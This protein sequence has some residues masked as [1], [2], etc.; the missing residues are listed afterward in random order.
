MAA[1]RRQLPRAAQQ[2]LLQREW[3]QS[4]RAAQQRFFS[5][6][7]GLCPACEECW[8]PGADLLSAQL[9]ISSTR[10]RAGSCNPKP[11]SLKLLKPQNHPKTPLKT[12]KTLNRSTPKP[13]NR[14]NPKP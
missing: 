4:A 10:L 1:L 14:L 6:T 12:L 9:L 2:W 3:L 8:P 7:S 13:L 11:L 5:P